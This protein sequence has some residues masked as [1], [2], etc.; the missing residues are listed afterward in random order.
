MSLSWLEIINFYMSSSNSESQ[1]WLRKKK[2][3]SLHCTTQSVSF[4]SRY[5]PARE[6]SIHVAVT[7]WFAKVWTVNL[8]PTALQSLFSFCCCFTL[9]FFSLKA[10]KLFVSSVILLQIVIISTAIESYI[11]NLTYKI[12]VWCNVIL[13][14]LKTSANPRVEWDVRA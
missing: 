8:T 11:I 5:T 6:I 1:T 10:N 3:K 14:N 12:I 7:H 2:R 13:L 9:F 4:W